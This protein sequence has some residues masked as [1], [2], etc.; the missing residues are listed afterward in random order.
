L[1]VFLTG[2]AGF[3]GSHVARVLVGKGHDVSVAVRETTDCWRI[4]DLVPRLRL[5]PCD[6]ERPET[7]TEQVKAVRPELAIHLAWYAVPG[8]YLT[9]PENS[10]M[11][12]ASIHLASELAAVGCGRFVGVGTCFE[13]DTALGYLSESSAIRPGSLY[14]A[15]KVALHTVLEQLGALSGME[16]AWAR[17]F[18]QFGPFEDERRLVPSVVRSLLRDEQVKV[19]T[20]EQYRDYLHVED[21]GAAIA[22]VAESDLTGPVNIG[23]GQPRQ[24]R[25]IVATIGRLL[26]REP[27]IRF[28]A[29]PPR[30]SDPIFVCANATRLRE[31]TTWTPRF[32]ELEPALQHTIDWWRR[33][34]GRA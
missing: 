6:L 3:I 5:L 14:A 26:G 25:E 9:A 17:L 32:A 30:P 21:V 13:Y 31:G 33:Q 7:V 2:G 12:C 1:R 10:G 20:G 18:Y 34:P 29:L 22:A 23:S 4:R 11:L 28:G 15:T 24:I 16:V 27:L 8:H 19:T